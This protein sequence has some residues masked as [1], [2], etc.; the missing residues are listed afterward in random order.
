MKGGKGLNEKVPCQEG[1]EWQA[2]R[3]IALRKFVVQS[4]LNTL[5]TAS[6]TSPIYVF[7]ESK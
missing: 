3:P 6:P 2:S 5:R 4:G 7:V 1:A